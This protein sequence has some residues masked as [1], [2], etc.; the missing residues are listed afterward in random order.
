MAQE[1][2]TTKKDA[3][4]KKPGFCVSGKD[5]SFFANTEAEAKKIMKQ[6]VGTVGLKILKLDPKDGCYK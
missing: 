2:K 5:L 4:P 1:K 6:Y 3:V